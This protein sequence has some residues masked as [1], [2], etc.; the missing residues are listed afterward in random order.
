MPLT[1]RLIELSFLIVLARSASPS[2]IYFSIETLIRAN[3]GFLPLNKYLYIPCES[4]HAPSNKKAFIKGELMR[5]ARNISSFMSFS[6]TRISCGSGYALEGILSDFCFR[7]FV[8]L[9][10][11]DREK[12]LY[13]KPRNRSR[14]RRTII[15][16]TTFNCSHARIKNVISQII[17]DLDCTVC[18][19]KTVTLAY[20][21]KQ[22]VLGDTRMSW[23]KYVTNMLHF[24]C[25][26][27]KNLACL[28]YVNP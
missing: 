19:K 22:A 14:L 8:L 6:K 16:K 3:C 17:P 18:Y 23:Q 9:R 10:Y 13:Q 26:L 7:C 4:F 20:L 1:T 5:Y 11:N 21:C 27:R 24:S 28:L 25:A 12:W 2:W 15:F